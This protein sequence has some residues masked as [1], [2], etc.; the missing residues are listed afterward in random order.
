MFRQFADRAGKVEVCSRPGEGGN[1]HAA[2]G[3]QQKISTFNV[4]LLCGGD[5]PEAL[6]QRQHRSSGRTALA[7][8]LPR[9]HRK[10]SIPP[11]TKNVFPEQEQRSSNESDGNIRTIIIIL[12]IANILYTLVNSGANGIVSSWCGQPAP[13]DRLRGARHGLWISLGHTGSLCERK[14]THVLL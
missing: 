14:P 4:Y 6:Q 8:C 2:F 10:P 12:I 1:A 13:R 5:G 9:F 7:L 11:Q 3:H